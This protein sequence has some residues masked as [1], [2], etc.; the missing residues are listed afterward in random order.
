[1]PQQMQYLRQAQRQT[2]ALHSGKVVATSTTGD[3]QTIKRVQVSTNIYLYSKD[4]NVQV[5]E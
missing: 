1:M 2:L 3:P 5:I 4:I